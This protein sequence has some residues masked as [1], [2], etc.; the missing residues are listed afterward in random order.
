MIGNPVLVKTKACGR[1]ARSRL[2][3]SR[4]QRVREAK[5]PVVTNAIADKK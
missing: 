3:I 1:Q 4:M 2:R 5:A